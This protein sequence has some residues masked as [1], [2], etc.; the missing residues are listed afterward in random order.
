[1]FCHPMKHDFRKKCKAVP[2]NMRRAA[3]GLPH[4]EGLPDAAPKI[5][6]ERARYFTESMKQTEGQHLTLRWAKALKNI[7]EKNDRLHR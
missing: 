3:S 1:M 7:A 2:P 6:I 4:H 5:D